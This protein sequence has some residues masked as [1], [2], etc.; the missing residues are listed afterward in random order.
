M[1][2]RLWLTLLVCFLFCNMNVFASDDFQMAYNEL[3]TY[4]AQ[5]PVEY[6]TGRV[7]AV[8][9][10]DVKSGPNEIYDKVDVIF[11]GTEIEVQE[12]EGN[13][14]YLSDGRGW[15]YAGFLSRK[16]DGVWSI[17]SEE[18][19]SRYVGLVYEALIDLPGEV[20]D[21]VQK[22]TISLVSQPVENDDVAKPADS[23]LYGLTTFG[24]DMETGEDVVKNIQVMTHPDLYKSILYHECGHAYCFDKG[25]LDDVV[26]QKLMIDNQY[27]L[28]YLSPRMAPELLLDN[29]DELFAEAFSLYMMKPEELQSRCEDVYNFFA[30]QFSGIM[31]WEE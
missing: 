22:Y 9:D 28:M 14:A 13:W 24:S 1:W 3:I 27:V 15:V 21:V 10:L 29:Y 7:Y 2:K 5:T 17:Y 20:K 16:W 6:P 30:G 4:V 31:I 11:T 19:S 12:V 8:T 25:Y 18:L 26:A 23:V